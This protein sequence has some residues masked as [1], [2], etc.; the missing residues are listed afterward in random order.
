[1]TR[2]REI[3][4]C[5]ICGNIVEVLHEGAALSCCGKQMELLEENVSDG[6]FE[7]HVPVVELADGGFRV[8]VG[9]LEHP[10]TADHCIQWIELLTPTGVLRRELQPGDR[11]EVLFLVCHD[12]KCRLAD[13]SAR[14]YCNLH[15]LWRK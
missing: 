8:R 13:V 4:R 7:K 3:Y 11:P 14:A 15:G 9:A 10:M 5:T 12:E 1:M 6:A 2:K